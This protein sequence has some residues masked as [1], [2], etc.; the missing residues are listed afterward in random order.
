MKQFELLLTNV[1]P[2]AST[3]LKFGAGVNILQGKNGVGKSTAIEAATAALSTGKEGGATV[4]DGHLKG[5]VAIDGVVVVM[6]GKKLT[7]QGQPSIELGGFSPI[8]DLIDPGLKDQLKADAVRVKAVLAMAPIEVSDSVVDALAQGD[9]EIRKIRRPEGAEQNVLA[10]ADHLRREAHRLALEAEKTEAVSR[11][12]ADAKSAELAGATGAGPAP[13]LEEAEKLAQAALESLTRTRLLASNRIEAEER[14]ARIA[15]TLGERPS[16]AEQEQEL[17]VRGQQVKA[18]EEEVQ[19]LE[20]LLKE[21]KDFLSGRRTEKTVAER[22]LAGAQHQQGKWDAQKAEIDKPLTG[23]TVQ[24]VNAADET[25]KTAQDNLRRAQANARVKALQDE[26]GASLALGE[27]SRTRA[28]R[29]RELATGVSAAL[30]EVLG[31]HGISGL[32]VEEGRLFAVVDG[33]R[34]LFGERLS[35]GQKVRIALDIALK[36]YKGRWI[37]LA[38]QFWSALQPKS[39]AELAAIALEREVALVTEMPTDDD[40]I[41]VVRLP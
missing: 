23:P 40:Q 8:G 38:P 41:S 6:V 13:T 10:V 4:R 26:V 25:L 19:R 22:M 39:Q 20:T 35:F 7:K 34:Q 18:A 14:N 11:S 16:V 29:L 30:G 9:E 12:V 37:P 1:G 27:V 33:K 17:V 24:D 21:A 5:T 31:H 3:T 36:A 15:A 32:D 28:A 2:H